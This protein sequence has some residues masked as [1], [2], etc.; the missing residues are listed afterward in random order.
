M[1]KGGV[2][3]GWTKWKRLSGNNS[4]QD[5]RKKRGDDTV[6]W[7]GGGKHVLLTFQ[8]FKIYGKWILFALDFDKKDPFILCDEFCILYHQEEKE[9]SSFSFLPCP[10]NGGGGGMEK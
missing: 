1:R 2:E 6:S 9:G 3:G 4:G 10:P 7:I 5:I 8:L